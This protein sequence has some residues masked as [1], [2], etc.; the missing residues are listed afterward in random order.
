[1]EN[2]IEAKETIEQEADYDI[3]DLL[4]IVLTF[5]V[6]GLVMTYGGDIQQDVYDDQTAGSISQTIANNSLQ[7]TQTFSEKSNTIAKVVIAAVII[8]I[9]MSYF[10]FRYR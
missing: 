2:E 7:T 4:A 3:K 6:L 10:Y 5:I 1:M 8:G 9:L